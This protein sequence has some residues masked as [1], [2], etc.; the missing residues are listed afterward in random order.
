LLRIEVELL[1]D[2]LQAVFAAQHSTFRLRLA[3]QCAKIL[4]AQDLRHA[5][6]ECQRQQLAHLPNPPLRAST[7]STIWGI[8][9]A[10]L[11]AYKRATERSNFERPNHFFVATWPP[12]K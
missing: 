2:V 1:A 4:S 11:T 5:Q 6:D 10:N 3:A 7:G 9:P 8:H 12:A